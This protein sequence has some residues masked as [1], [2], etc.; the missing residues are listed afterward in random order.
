MGDRAKPIVDLGKVVTMPRSGELT[1]ALRAASGPAPE[2]MKELKA[3][4]AAKRLE[5]GLT[6]NA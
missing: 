4:V 3:L 5:R 2:G 6:S 1:E